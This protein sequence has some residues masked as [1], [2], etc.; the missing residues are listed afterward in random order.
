MSRYDHKI[1]TS[2]EGIEHLS[3]DKK[4]E[5]IEKRMVSTVVQ[6]LVTYHLLLQRQRQLL[7]AQ[8]ISV[9]ISESIW[10]EPKDADGNRHDYKLVQ[11]EQALRLLLFPSFLDSQSYRKDEQKREW[12]LRSYNIWFTI[13]SFIIS[14]PQK[15][16]W[17]METTARRNL[18][19]GGC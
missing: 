8:A 18:S 16:K 5:K 9:Q 4:E 19:H 10:D 2:L 17:K 14:V 15:S 7:Q 11:Q 3:K 12:S 1:E 13:I 6:H